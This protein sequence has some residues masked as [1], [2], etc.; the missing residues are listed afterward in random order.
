VIP[1]CV[2]HFLECLVVGPVLPIWGDAGTQRRQ[3]EGQVTRGTLWSFKSDGVHRR[4]S[5]QVLG[6]PCRKARVKKAL[7]TGHLPLQ[8]SLICWV[9]GT[10]PLS[11]SADQSIISRLL[12][13]G[14][15]S[16]LILRLF[17]PSFLLLAA[18]RHAL[19]G[20]T[21]IDPCVQVWVISAISLFR[22]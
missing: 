12:S 21:Y 14:S 5:L 10:L 16:C 13:I 6:S 1:L 20:W 3:G 17:A 9:C 15:L 18:L 8:D 19:I 4:T 11:S 2:Q 22:S 7:K